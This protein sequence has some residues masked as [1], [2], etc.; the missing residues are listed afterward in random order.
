MNLHYR[1]CLRPVM[2]SFVRFIELEVWGGDSGHGM[3][4]HDRLN[5][6]PVSVML[7]NT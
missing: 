6:A 5:A 2:V 4:A 3:L 7:A 1:P